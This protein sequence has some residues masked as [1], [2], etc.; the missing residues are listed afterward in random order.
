VSD[1]K[2][3]A[4]DGFPLGVS[5]TPEEKNKKVLDK[6]TLLCYNTITV[7]G[8]MATL[9]EYNEMRTNKWL[10]IEKALPSALQTMISCLR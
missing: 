7:E 3:L 5:K 6:K 1:G 9:T 4:Q 10:T 2:P 8:A